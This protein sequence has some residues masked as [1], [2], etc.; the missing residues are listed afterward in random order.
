[1][2]HIIF[3]SYFALMSHFA[4]VLCKPL[5][6]QLIKLQLSEVKSKALFSTL[7]SHYYLNQ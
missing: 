5:Y 4:I 3:L 6:A 1:M 7:V 2:I